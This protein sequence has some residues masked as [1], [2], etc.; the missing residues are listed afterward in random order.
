MKNQRG[1]LNSIL[2]AAVRQLPNGTIYIIAMIYA[3]V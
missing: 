2:K 3:Y 1:L